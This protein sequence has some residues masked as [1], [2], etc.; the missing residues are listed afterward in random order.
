M[1]KLRDYQQNL[2]DQIYNS[3]SP[4]NCVQ[5]STGS[6]K[7]IIFSYLANNF[8]GRVL[9]LVNRNELLE[10]TAKNITNRKLL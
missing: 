4:R 5:S 1:I 10:Q 3:S 2:V 6:G 7:T 8:K 9:I